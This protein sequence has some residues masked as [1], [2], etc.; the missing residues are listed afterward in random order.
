MTD[1]RCTDCVHCAP[2]P[3]RVELL[4]GLPGGL[5]YHYPTHA[6]MASRTCVM[7]V[8]PLDAPACPDFERGKRIDYIKEF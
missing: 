8:H 1:N 2:W 4:R 6:C 7:A 3:E 5:P